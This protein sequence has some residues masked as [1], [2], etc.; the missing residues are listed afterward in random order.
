MAAKTKLEL[1]FGQSDLAV[2]LY[3]MAIAIIR[4][5]LSSRSQSECWVR[6]ILRA[7]RGERLSSW[8]AVRVSN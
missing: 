4:R 8:N 7:R 5:T 6:E 3:D 1:T 2:S